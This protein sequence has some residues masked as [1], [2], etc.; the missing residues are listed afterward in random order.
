MARVIPDGEVRIWAVTTIA[1]K[2]APTV[3]EINAGT[4]VTPRVSSLETPNDGE[5]VPANDLSSA[6]NKTV[7]G[8]FGGAP[9]ASMFRDQ[10]SASVAD[11][12]FNLFPRNTSQFVVVRRFGGSTLAPAIGH[13]VDVFPVRVI[14][15]SAESLDSGS[16]QMFT[17]NWAGTDEPSEAV[18]LV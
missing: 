8:R 17:V 15:R 16:I 13:L 11:T 7:T 2:A 18:A 1:N 4:D 10:A 5:A 6:Y 9:S 12:V 3:A 14:S